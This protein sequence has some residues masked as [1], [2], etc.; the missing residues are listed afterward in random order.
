MVADD[1]A[2]EALVFGE[3][4][5]ARGLPRDG[6]HLTSGTISVAL[7]DRITALHEAAGQIHVSTPVL[8]STAGG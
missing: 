2:T 1:T 6:I 4:G 5:V 8:G 3:H 7:S